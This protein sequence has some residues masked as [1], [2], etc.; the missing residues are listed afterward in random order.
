MKWN[1]HTM[2]INFS[3]LLFRY[4]QVSHYC[5]CIAVPKHHT[6]KA[7]REKFENLG[8]EVSLRW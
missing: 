6:I 7:F 3:P 1:L 2:E 5:M 4:R 8:T